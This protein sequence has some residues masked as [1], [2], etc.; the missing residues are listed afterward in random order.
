M[1]R[2][3]SPDGEQ[4]E[5]GALY[6][7]LQFPKGIFPVFLAHTIFTMCLLDII[8]LLILWLEKQA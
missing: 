3:P 7:G 1:D 4:W 2:V 6:G 8:I 5:Q